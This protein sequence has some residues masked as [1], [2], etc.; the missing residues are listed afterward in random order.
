MSVS[1]QPKDLLEAAKCVCIP[2]G[3]LREVMIYLLCQWANK[4][5][6]PPVI[7]WVPA[8]ALALW[9]DSGGVNGGDLASFKANADLPTVVVLVAGGLSLTSLSG[10]ITLPALTGID[11][12]NN[13]LTA[14]GSI[15]QIL[16]DLVTNGKLG[17]TCDVNLQ[18][19]A[20]PPTVGPP[21][22]I[23]AKAT[24]LTRGWTVNTD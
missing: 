2:K 16:T 7:D 15:N 5:V 19:P 6:P 23:A 4:P 18:T 21:S 24:L 13:K 8:S 3:K 12:T 22:G 14:A 17:G 11:C 20:A 9:I 1:C 10:I